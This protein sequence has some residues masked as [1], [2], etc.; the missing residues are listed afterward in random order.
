MDEHSLDSDR[1]RSEPVES[2]GVD[3][4]AWELRRIKWALWAIAV[5]TFLALPVSC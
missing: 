5:L 3:L 4:V 1:G 2:S